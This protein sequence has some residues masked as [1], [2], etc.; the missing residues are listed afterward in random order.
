[1]QGQAEVQHEDDT[2]WI[3]VEELLSLE[4]IGKIER[5]ILTHGY[6]YSEYYLA[7]D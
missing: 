6:W 1:M 2:L 4:D 7:E 5:V 3:D